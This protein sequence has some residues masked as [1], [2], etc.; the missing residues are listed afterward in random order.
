M[1]EVS[2]VELVL[3]VMLRLV[4]TLFILELGDIYSY[5][6]RTYDK[7]CYHNIRGC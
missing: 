5:Y 7:L 6:G 1:V 2:I 4:Q 3:I